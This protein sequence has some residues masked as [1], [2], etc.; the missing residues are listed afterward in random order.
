MRDPIITVSGRMSEM[1]QAS[2]E[3]REP[4]AGE[5]E[6][7]LGSMHVYYLPES[8]QIMFEH[9]EHVPGN[10]TVECPQC[11]HEIELDTDGEHEEPISQHVYDTEREIVNHLVKHAKLHNFRR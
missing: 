1:R 11:G 4:V 2:S 6:P 5:P 3:A 8:H 10:E 7:E 9:R